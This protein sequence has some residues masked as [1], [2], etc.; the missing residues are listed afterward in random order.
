LE[1]L[2][3][4]YGGDGNLKLSEYEEL[5]RIKGS[6]E[7]AVESALRAGAGSR[8]PQ[9]RAAQFAVVRRAFIPWLAGIDPET[10]NPR[11]RV[12]R[13]SEIPEEARPLVQLLVEQRLLATDV[14][15]DSGEV[16][17]EPAHEALLRQWGLLQTWLVED[18]AALA[19]LE[20]VKRAAL[21]WEASGKD[22]SWLTHGGGRL[23]DAE[24]L[25]LGLISPGSWDRPIGPISPPAARARPRRK[26]ARR[27]SRSAHG[28]GSSSRAFWR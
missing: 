17:I 7:A 11:R 24:R 27:R 16:T 21:D 15:K 14:A 19:A 8:T 3:E 2:Y 25:R 12:A 6:I 13:L 9:D 1:R 4:D 26:S 5:G 18:S 10:G 28:S 23:E 22:S 20:S